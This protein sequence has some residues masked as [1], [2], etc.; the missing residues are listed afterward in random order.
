LAVTLLGVG[1]PRHGGEARGVDVHGQCWED[2]DV[3]DVVNVVRSEGPGL[4]CDK[5]PGLAA[6]ANTCLLKQG[7]R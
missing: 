4:A 7:A 5:G 2:T 3:G 1:I 6:A